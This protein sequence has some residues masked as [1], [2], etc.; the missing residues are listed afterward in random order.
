[1]QTT[2]RI[3]RNSNIPFYP[4]LAYNK[5]WIFT[6]QERPVPKK[7]ITWKTFETEHLSIQLPDTFIAG[8]PSR[9]R[10]ALQAAV[11]E[12]PDDVR[13]VF[14]SLF[15]QRNFVFLAADRNFS[16][17]MSSLTCLVV[18]PE[19]I[20]FIQFNPRIENYIKAVKKNLGRNFETIEEEYFEF[21]GL[22]AVRL[23]SAQRA[24]KTRK[25][26]EP[27]IK[28]QHLLYAFRL[29][30]HYWAFDWIADI[31]VFDKYLPV[32]DQSIK[33]LVFKEKAR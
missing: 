6:E 16:N 22:S 26:P 30:R 23:L 27:D 20:P 28:R 31:S 3:T 17:D 19:S 25:D 2:Y 29:R 4:F 12:L 11:N 1:V 7:K 14:K 15:A 33:S 24:P 18:L 5:R 8:Q 21:Q 10:K 13:N 9:D 32:F